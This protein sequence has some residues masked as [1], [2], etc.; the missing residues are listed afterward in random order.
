MADNCKSIYEAMK[1]NNKENNN[2]KTRFFRINDKKTEIIHID[3]DD[4]P[5]DC[6]S[7]TFDQM[8]EM[9][10]NHFSAQALYILHDLAYMSDDGRPQNKLIIINW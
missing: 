8:K 2:R 5:P 6:P 3:D 9:V 10:K 4:L 7:D 1:M